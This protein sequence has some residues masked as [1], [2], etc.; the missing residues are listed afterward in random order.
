L[1]EIV[2]IGTSDAFGAGGRRQAAMLIRTASGAVLLDCGP[3]TL[4]GLAE[5][6]IPRDEIDAI[7]VSH[8]HGDHFGGIPL[9]LLA[10]IHED[11]RRH[12]LEILGPPGV[13]ERV[14]AAS[15]ALG[16]PIDGRAMPFVLGFREFTEGGD[17]SAGP[18]EVKAFGVNHDQASAPHGFVVSANRRR[19]AY[20]GDTGWFDAL[21]GHVQDADL[22]ICE[23][24]QLERVYPLHL[25]YADLLEHKGAFKCGRMILTHLGFEMSARRGACAFETADDGLRIP[26]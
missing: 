1:A 26:L 17:L 23:C 9:F 7:V 24:T 6:G 22:F 3:T 18:V 5:L 15:A 20:T 8:Y 2:F 25:S 10:A 14:I 13:V 19:I 21:P 16:H 4:T 12:P 11:R